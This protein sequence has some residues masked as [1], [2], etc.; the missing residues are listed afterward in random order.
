M[1]VTD[2]RN[3]HHRKFTQLTRVRVKTLRSDGWK[4]SKKPTSNNSYEKSGKK[5]N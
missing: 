3:F 2:N 1:M 5:K 4:G